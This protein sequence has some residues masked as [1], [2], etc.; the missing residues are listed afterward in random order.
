MELLL[1][2]FEPE[3]AMNWAVWTKNYNTNKILKDIVAKGKCGRAVGL[4]LYSR[5]TLAA[6]RRG[7]TAGIS[8]ENITTVYTWQYSALHRSSIDIL[9][10]RAKWKYYKY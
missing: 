6:N 1:S 7:V 8:C 10:I 9:Q 2:G 5:E 4:K 3:H